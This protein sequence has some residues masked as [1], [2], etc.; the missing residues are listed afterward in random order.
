MRG[1]MTA[2]TLEPAFMKPVAVA[3]CFW[4]N[5]S[6]IVLMAVGKLAASQRPRKKRARPNCMAV[7]VKAVKMPAR[8]QPTMARA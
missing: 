3:R 2:P 4:G 8:D 7:P 5:H 1:A 6:A